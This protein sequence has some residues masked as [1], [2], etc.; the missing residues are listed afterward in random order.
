ML[1]WLAEFLPSDLNN[2]H[3]TNTAAAR[4]ASTPAAL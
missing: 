2:E 1:S 3:T 4:R